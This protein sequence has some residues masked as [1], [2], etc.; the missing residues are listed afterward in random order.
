MFDPN[1]YKIVQWIGRLGYIVMI[2]APIYYILAIAD[3]R[4]Q[5]LPM[6]LF[7]IGG[8]IVMLTLVFIQLELL[9]SKRDIKTIAMTAFFI[10]MIAFFFMFLIFG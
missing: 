7:S 8:L 10:I 2:G 1:R 4:L 6:T 5:V 9:S 3:E